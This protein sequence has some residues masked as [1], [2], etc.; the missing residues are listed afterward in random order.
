[1]AATPGHCFSRGVHNAGRLR[2]EVVVQYP[3]HP[4]TGQSV[5]VVG[6]T[7]HG[8]SR[9]LIVRKSDGAKLLLPAWMTFREA[10]SVTILSCPRLS[11]SRL[12]ELRAL[13][14]RLMASDPPKQIPGGVQSDEAMEAIKPRSLQ[15]AARTS[16]GPTNN[17]SR[18][19]EG[20]ADRGN[21]HNKDRHRRCTTSG[22]GRKQRR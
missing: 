13:V 5:L 19:A 1:L 17:S 15:H 7:E 3:Y 16:R 18:A 4:L 10:G 22:C 9:H 8:G 6:E 12:I 11:V 21:V 20:A 2:F 14:D